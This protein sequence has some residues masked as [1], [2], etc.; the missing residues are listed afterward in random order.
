MRSLVLLLLLALGST[1]GQKNGTNTATLVPLIDR[2]PQILQMGA[3][4]TFTLQTKD[5]PDLGDA[6][7]LFEVHTHQ[8]PIHF[9]RKGNDSSSST[10]V[11]P[12]PTHAGFILF[13]TDLATNVTFPTV[14]VTNPNNFTV[15]AI[16]L[17]RA[18][19]A[20]SPVPGSCSQVNETSLVGAPELN[21]SWD[22]SLVQLNFSLSG[23]IGAP[24]YFCN[25]SSEA[26]GLKYS[27]YVKYLDTRNFDENYLLTELAETMLLPETI[28]SEGTLVL[29]AFVQDPDLSMM[30]NVFFGAYFGIPSLYAVIVQHGNNQTSTYVTTATYACSLDPTKYWSCNIICNPLT[31]VHKPTA[32]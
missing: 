4:A 9:Q 15:S 19:D 3:N 25:I 32:I 17:V 29:D 1:S 10:V 30:K 21:L 2:E 31:K 12:D 20:G 26:A 5:A 28:V 18:H 11:V 22:D 13:K 6:F 24:D 14:N 27:V 23:L 7:W 16:F 8:Y